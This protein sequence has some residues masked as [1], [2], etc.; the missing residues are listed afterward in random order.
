MNVRSLLSFAWRVRQ[1]RRHS[2]PQP[3]RRVH[4][5][6][7]HCRHRRHRHRRASQARVVDAGSKPRERTSLP[8]PVLSKQSAHHDVQSAHRTSKSTSPRAHPPLRLSPRARS[9]T[10]LRAPS[11]APMPA[12]AAETAAVEGTRAVRSMRRVT[13]TGS[14]RLGGRA[15]RGARVLV[16]GR[17]SR[18]RAWGGRGAGRGPARGRACSRCL[19]TVATGRAPGGGA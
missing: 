6:R 7:R 12:S 19:S 13:R 1:L 14:G 17:C 5:P 16:K 4:R 15:Q 9:P 8:H 3:D 10:R 2:A 11:A 18:R